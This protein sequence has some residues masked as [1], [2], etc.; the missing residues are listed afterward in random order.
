MQSKPNFSGPTILNLLSDQIKTDKNSP[1][2]QNQ[3]SEAPFLNNQE[4]D[5]SPRFPLLE[6]ETL[7]RLE[8]QIFQRGTAEFYQ[9]DPAEIINQK[10]E[11][12]LSDEQKIRKKLQ[13]MSMRVLSILRYIS[14]N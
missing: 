11:I 14:P 5:I 8:D 6:D 12:P 4:A 7:K 1:A 9:L 3:I 10:N 13:S 2:Q